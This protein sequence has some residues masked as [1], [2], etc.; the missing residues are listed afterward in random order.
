MLDEKLVLETLSAVIDPDFNKNIV[1]LGFVKN[2]VITGKE[3]AFNLELTT[4]ACP[5]KEEFLSQCQSLLKGVGFELVNIALT[6]A[7]RPK[8]K[9]P[10]LAGVKQILA[11]ASCKGGVGKST[12]AAMVATELARRGH[13]TGLLDADI[14]G[15]SVPTL[16][17][18]RD[19]DLS[20]DENKM[21]HPHPVNDFLRVMSFGFLLGDSPAIMRGPMVANYI[22]QLIFQVD[23][24]DLDTLVIDMPPG[25]GDV[26]LTLTQQLQISGAVIVTTPHTLSMVDVSKGILMFER[27]NVPI[28][29]VIENMAYVHC[30]K[31]HEKNYIFGKPR[32]ELAERF[33]IPT[34]AELPIRPDYSRDFSEEHESEEIS[35]AVDRIIR[36]LGK[37]SIENKEIPKVSFTPEKITFTWSEGNTSEVNHRELRLSCACAL[38][39]DEKTG[40]K[41]L[42]PEMVNKSIQALEITPIGNYAVGIKWN[43]GHTSG[44]YPYKKIRELK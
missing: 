28:L 36:Q 41:I 31:C 2:V 13:P 29:G 14:H 24:G 30:H 33:G 25:T 39:I 18:I 42:K 12:I 19:P 15:P 4:P 40:V 37:R 27:V 35:E 32:G 44:I 23:W 7:P 1:S 3:I 5:V 17:G 20:Q 26:Q 21:L 11:I 8:P 34:L 6:S 10:G 9:A 38:C 43:D 16:F 22:Q